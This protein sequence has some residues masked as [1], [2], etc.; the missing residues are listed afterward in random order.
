MLLYMCS[1]SPPNPISTSPLQRETTRSIDQ[2]DR[3][4]SSSRPTMPYAATRT[5]PQQ[6]SRV[7]SNGRAVAACAGHA[8]VPDEVARHHEHAVAAGQCCSVMVQSIAAPADAVWSLVR[9]FDQPQ[10]YKRFI[11]SCHLVDG[12]GVEVGSVRELLVVSG[13]PAENSRER[14]EIRDDER[15]VISFRILGGDHR[16]AN[17]RSV[18]TVHEAAS[19]G[20]PLTMVVESY[21]VDVPP[22]NTVEETRIFVD[23]IVRCNLQ[24][25][26]DTV[27]R[28][29]AM[30]APA[31]PHNDHNHS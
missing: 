25:L 16:L 30:A 17:Y 8:G 14:L 21:V 15:R 5:S 1:T 3:R 28:Q 22:G 18:T 4:G 24:S 10:G 2:E 26:E 23:T 13:L 11:R 29:Q 7:A 31:A 9:R 27:I 6:H 19:E 20:G 12:D